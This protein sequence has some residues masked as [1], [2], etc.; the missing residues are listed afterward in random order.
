MK[1]QH[2]IQDCKCGIC[3]GE[4][5]YK[6]IPKDNCVV[7]DKKLKFK[8][9][10]YKQHGNYCALCDAKIAGITKARAKLEHGGEQAQ[11][12]LEKAI[13]KIRQ[14]TNIDFKPLKQ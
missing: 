12:K 4:I 8:P 5:E 7:C 1:R 10:D 2:K 11:T 9:A 3:T 14:Y 13:S 6:V